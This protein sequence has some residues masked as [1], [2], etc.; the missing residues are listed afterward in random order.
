MLK[1]VQIR[2]KAKDPEL[3]SWGDQPCEEARGQLPSPDTARHEALRN[4]GAF[5]ADFRP[6]LEEAQSRLICCDKSLTHGHARSQLRKRGRATDRGVRP[7]PSSAMCLTN[8]RHCVRDC[9][10]GRANQQ[11]VVRVVHEYVRPGVCFPSVL[12]L[13]VVVGGRVGR[14]GLA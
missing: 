2:T 12:V 6:R 10:R 4:T 9:C 5:R 8:V 3:F 1:G 14:T 11:Q 13:Y 7:S